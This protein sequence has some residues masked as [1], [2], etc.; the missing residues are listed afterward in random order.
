MYTISRIIGIIVVF[1]VAAV[2]WVALAAVTA[3]RSSTQSEK[4]GPEVQNLWGH[5]QAQSAPA[6][7]FTW[8]TTRQTDETVEEGKQ[9]RHVKKTVEDDHA[10]D[11]LPSAAT[12]RADIHLDHRLKGLLWYALYDVT[13]DGA[14]SYVHD[15]PEAGRLEIAFA[16][17]VPDAVY[18][19]FQFVV[20]GHDWAREV[21]PENGYVT[22]RVD[23]HS[24][25]TVT[26]Q[27]HYRSRGIDQWSYRPATEGVASLQNFVL[28][29]GCDFADIDYPAD[30]MSPSQRQRGGG[31][32]LLT[33]GFKQVL[34]GQSM[35][36]VMPRRLQPGEL[37]TSLAASA[38]V[39]LLL[40]FIVL[41][42]LSVRY[43]LDIHPLNYLA[44]AGAFFAF[45]LLFAYSVD[46]IQIAPAFGLAS[47]ASI[48]LVVSYLRLVVSPR[49]AYRRA[50]VAQLVYQVGFSI[51]HFWDG[52]TGL[53]VSVLATLTLFL[54]MQMTGRVSWTNALKKPARPDAPVAPATGAVQPKTDLKTDLTL[55]KSG[56]WGV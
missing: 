9:I 21:R 53:S 5:P 36:L 26:L 31:G 13:F 38:P 23:L 6:F 47:A 48:G 51:A 41:F 8:K 42:V 16:F 1:C 43:Q 19:D 22:F 11:V 32:W 15:Q 50:A 24:S 33:W 40:F 46:H 17:P 29:V 25:Q 28:T 55:A 30:A 10:R 54:V 4:L 7:K 39:S 14:W 35:G 37:A 2:G 12:L 27:V 49:F 20:N 56:G 34:T 3:Q 18:D 45:H 44:I 52:Y